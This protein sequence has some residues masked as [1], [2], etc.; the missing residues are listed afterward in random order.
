M[1]QAN[2]LVFLAEHISSFAVDFLSSGVYFNLP[3]MTNVNKVTRIESQQI[4]NLIG[5]V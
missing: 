2:W 1:N 4:V 3:L 5:V